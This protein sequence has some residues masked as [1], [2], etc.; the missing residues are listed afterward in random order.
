MKQLLQTLS[1]GLCL[2]FF[3]FITAMAGDN[4]APVTTTGDPQ[5]VTTEIGDAIE[6]DGIGDRILVHNNPLGDTKEFTVEVYFKPDASY[7]ETGV[8][9]EPRFIHIQ[10]T[11]DLQEKRVMMELRITPSNEWYLDGFMKTDASQLTLVEPNNTH[12]TEDWMH[13]AITFKNDTFRTYVNGKEELKGH[14]NFTTAIVN[15]VGVTSI[16]SRMNRVNFYKVL[17][18]TLKITHKALL[19]GEFLIDDMPS[20]T[21]STL[22]NLDVQTFPNPAASNLNISFNST[23]AENCDLV[24]YDILGN[25]ALIKNYITQAGRNNITIDTSNFATGMYLVSLK[26]SNDYYSGKINI[27]H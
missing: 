14:I 20:K 27:R 22:M 11:T 25:I 2:F 6:F 16:G 17:V 10:D 9:A 13:A 5:V 23:K 3:V 19:P 12:P 4:D 1:L 7:G 24:I 26:S 15:T 21:N 18:K 8:T